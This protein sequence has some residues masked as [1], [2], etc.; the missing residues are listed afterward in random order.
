MSFVVA[1]HLF[2]P[3]SLVRLGQVTWFQQIE[4]GQRDGMPLLGL[5][6]KKTATSILGTPS[7][8]SLWG[9]WLPCFELS[10]GETPVAKI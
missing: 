1:M 8:S 7:H 9:K 6:Y 2:N 5:G 4:Y 10:Y 3:I